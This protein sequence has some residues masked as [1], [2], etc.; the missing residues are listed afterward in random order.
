[1][2]LRPITEFGAGL[3][4]GTALGPQGGLALAPGETAGKWMSDVLEVAPFTW[5]VASW[6]GTG[7]RLEVALR[8]E[9]P[10]GGWS[11][12]FSFGEWSATG[13]RGSVA[14]QRY[15]GVGRLA[16]DTLLLE[17][18][19]TRVQ[20]S[21]SL[22]HGELKRLWLC[23][24]MPAERSAEE[25]H[26]AA[27]GVDLDVPQRSQMVYPNG[28]NVWCS[29]TSLTMVMA[30]YGHVESVPDDAVPGVYDAVY[31]G[32]GNWPFNTAYASTRGFVGYVDRFQSF[33][34]L[35]R[36]IAAGRP[37]IASVAYKREWL[38]NAPIDQTGGHILVV[39]GFTAVGD[40]IVNDPAA[41]DD[42]GVRLI[43]QRD[44][45]RRAWLDRGGVVY[46][47]YPSP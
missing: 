28:G 16:T 10:G 26:R 32:H 27:W 37:V 33:A 47:I 31:D 23:T 25:E 13:R 24:A 41:A 36:M 42:S 17:Q 2:P 12:W 45:F 44:L 4:A 39:R 15:E 29:P 1:M 5:A 20:I 8:V 11:P 22:V 9:L 3:H 6:N 21:V 46:V 14:G 7:D 40:V 34:A 18:P 38:P 35:E 43:Y 19:A 30:Y